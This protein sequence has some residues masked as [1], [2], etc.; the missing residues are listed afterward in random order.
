MSVDVG[1]EKLG[2]AARRLWRMPAAWSRNPYIK[3]LRLRTHA[4]IFIDRRRGF[5]GLSTHN[6]TSW[7]ALQ[8]GTMKA[9]GFDIGAKPRKH[10]ELQAKD[11][12]PIGSLHLVYF[13]EVGVSFQLREKEALPDP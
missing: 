12:S 6:P 5:G 8:E 11:F 13:V 2:G 3:F 9:K 7:T 1:R 10:V 4:P